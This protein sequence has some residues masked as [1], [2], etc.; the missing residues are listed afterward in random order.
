[1]KTLLCALAACAA[2]L[3]GMA[4]EEV[5][6]GP[7]TVNVGPRTATVVWLVSDAQST[8]GE[9]PTDPK[10]TAQSVQVR[11]TVYSGLKANTT[12]YYTVPGAGQGHFKT[13]PA[14]P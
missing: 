7:Y 13:A 10:M 12:Y 6:A 8:L 1:M 14:P 4:G 11:K 5:V 2:P 9:S 3:I